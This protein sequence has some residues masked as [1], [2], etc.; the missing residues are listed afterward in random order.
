MAGCFREHGL[1]VEVLHSGLPQ[2]KR[3]AI[4]SG[5][6]AGLVDVVVQVQMLGEGY[7][8]GTLSVAA[9]FRPY[10]SLSPYIQFVGRIL[11]LAEPT[12]PASPGNR[13][14]AYPVNSAEYNI[15]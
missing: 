11:R 14:S 13:A 5:L 10:R 15:L 3:D 2:E 7:D 9:V 12:A 1:R 4:K 6:R 8:L